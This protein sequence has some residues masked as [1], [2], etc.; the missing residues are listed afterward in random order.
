MLVTDSD[1]IVTVA[2]RFIFLGG[3]GIFFAK[4][5]HVKIGHVLF[6][7]MT[8]IAIPYGLTAIAL[9]EIN[10]T[11]V[12]LSS[13]IEV[14]AAQLMGVVLLKEKLPPVVIFTS[15]ICFLGFYI[16]FGS[17]D[18]GSNHYLEVVFVVAAA[19]S[20]AASN[21]FIKK[22]KTQIIPL[23][24]YSCLAAGVELILFSIIYNKSNL[25]YSFNYIS[26]TSFFMTISIGVI[27]VAAFICWCLSLRSSGLIEISSY[28]LLT[29]LFA[30]LFAVLLLD[31][32]PGSQTIIGGI[33]VTLGIITQRKLKT[34]DL[35][36]TLSNMKS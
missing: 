9:K 24:I 29:P 33:I 19:I 21:V 11:V 7:S 20:F 32:Y 34:K 3:A 36:L 16:I 27:T 5:Q 23:V 30:S 13:L 35:C 25:G 4:R 1:P 15:L 2:I 6:L 28:I 8:M 17:P 18:V 22:I 14:V 10:S 26:W 31:E 12:S